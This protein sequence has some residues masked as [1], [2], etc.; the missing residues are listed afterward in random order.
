[1]KV[2]GL[3]PSRRR[4]LCCFLVPPSA[5]PFSSRTAF[6]S[7][8]S[9]LLTRR[10]FCL[11]VSESPPQGLH[12]CIC[13][14]CRLGLYCQFLAITSR[15]C[16]ILGGYACGDQLS[17]CTNTVLKSIWR[18]TALYHLPS[19]SAPSDEPGPPNATPVQNSL[20]LYPSQTSLGGMTRLKGLFAT[21][22]DQFTEN[23]V[24]SFSFQHVKET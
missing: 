22:T 6:M 20:N 8:T 13:R 24:Q 9:A 10:P 16:P 23:R 11:A 12:C 21:G 2:M 7:S 18:I 5:L 19:C 14:L 1:M 4:Y 3:A 17:I 15:L